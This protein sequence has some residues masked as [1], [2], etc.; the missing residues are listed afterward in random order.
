M[1][2]VGKKALLTIAAGAGSA[3]V[4]VMPTV[5][6]WFLAGPLLA[7]ATVAAF[8]WIRESLG[9]HSADQQRVTSDGSDPAI[10]DDDGGYLP[11]DEYRGQFKD[12]IPP[13]LEVVAA[14]GQEAVLIVGTDRNTPIHAQVQIL[15]VVPGEPSAAIRFLCCGGMSVRAG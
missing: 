10:S 7:V 11:S 9:T 5:H 3:A 12:T 8:L 4:V 2:N 1:A 15:E 13:R 6:S 14:S